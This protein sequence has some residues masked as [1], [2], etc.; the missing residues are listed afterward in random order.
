MEALRFEIQYNL[1]EIDWN[2]EEL[3]KFESEA[4]DHTWKTHQ[5]MTWK[6]KITSLLTC[7]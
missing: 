7:F 3:M 6:F 1:M 2:F 5:L 4:P